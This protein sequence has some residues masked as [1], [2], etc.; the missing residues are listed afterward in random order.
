[1]V[2]NRCPEPVPSERSESS[3]ARRAKDGHPPPFTKIRGYSWS[4]ALKAPPSPV[5]GVFPPPPY[6][7]RRCPHRLWA[8]VP[9][10]PPNGPFRKSSLR[11]QRVLRSSKSEGWTAN[12]RQPPQTP[13]RPLSPF[14]LTTPLHPLPSRRFRAWRGS[15]VV[16]HWSAKPVCAGSI[17]ALAST[18]SKSS[19]Y[20]TRET[21]TQ[22]R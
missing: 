20:V 18:P 16:M 5:P 3:V 6:W 14:T 10:H 2:C 4:F 17:P 9:V 15:K 8:D 13:L 12:N 19:C 21:Q 7:E 22:H 1:M 11:A